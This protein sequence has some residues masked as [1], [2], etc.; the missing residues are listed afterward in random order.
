LSLTHTTLC[1]YWHASP[2]WRQD[3][4]R[5]RFRS[6]LIP[7]TLQRWQSR[8]WR[9]PRGFLIRV[10]MVKFWSMKLLTWLGRLSTIPEISRAGVADVLA[11]RLHGRSESQSYG[12]DLFIKQKKR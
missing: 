4:H 2:P 10:I 8:S 3:W 5:G 9:M 6:H 12:T 7:R 1:G 11:I